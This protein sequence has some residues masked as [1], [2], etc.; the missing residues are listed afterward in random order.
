MYRFNRISVFIFLLILA[1][2][3][4]SKTNNS[5]TTLSKSIASVVL[6][7]D[8]ILSDTDL[9][10]ENA[11]Q[12]TKILNDAEAKADSFIESYKNIFKC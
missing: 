1:S 10:E 8:N 5:K 4:A 11:G 2:C 7:W 12:I 6:Y 3:V 9:S